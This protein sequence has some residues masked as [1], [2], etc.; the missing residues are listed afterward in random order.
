MRV[1]SSPNS[2]SIAASVTCVSSTVSWSSAASRVVVSR[3]RSARIA[4]T[5]TG[6]SMKSSPDLRFC[7]SCESWANMNARW[8]SFRSAFGL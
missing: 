5:A 1:T 3:R 4:V 7:P 8:I 2:S 6:C